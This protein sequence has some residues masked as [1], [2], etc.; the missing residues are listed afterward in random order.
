[1]NVI[2]IFTIFLLFFSP[3]LT[4]GQVEIK[5]P[6]QLKLERLNRRKAELIAEN[7][8]LY[9]DLESAK[10]KYGVLSEKYK[11]LSRQYS[12]QQENIKDKDDMINILVGQIKE[13]DEA[14]AEN[15]VQLK[16][17]TDNN[18]RLESTMMTIQ[19]DNEILKK[20]LLGFIE[21][22]GVGI[23]DG[24]V[25]F[26]TTISLE[27]GERSFSNPRALQTSCKHLMYN[28]NW[29]A[30]KMLSQENYS[31]SIPGYVFVY[32]NNEYNQH[33]AVSLNRD[34]TSK[35]VTMNKYSIKNFAHEL[36]QPLKEKKEYKF[37]FVPKYIFDLNI[38]L[39]MSATYWDACEK[40][41]FLFGTDGNCEPKNYARP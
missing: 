32:E 6:L 18:N 39:L 3:S 22:H 33:V 2:K 5:S 10:T 30:S 37:A 40:G 11:S 20:E 9:D 16:R 36:N 35:L 1:M 25:V 8:S 29:I 34:Y 4:Y 28:M 41:M 31:K 38:S 7:K 21:V 13:R 27:T 12:D 15:T 19:A 23:K 17:S 26:K 14:L 24:E